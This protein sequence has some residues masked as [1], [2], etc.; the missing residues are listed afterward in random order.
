MSD[1]KQEKKEVKLPENVSVDYTFERM[2]KSFIKQV[3]KDGV[4]QEIRDRRYYQKPSVIRH[5]LLGTIKRKQKL[6]RRR[7]RNK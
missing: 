1:P 3:E 2:L 5:K 7:K 6:Q 4:L